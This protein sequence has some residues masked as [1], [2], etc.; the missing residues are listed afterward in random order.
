MYLDLAKYSM[1]EK[2]MAKIAYENKAGIERLSNAYADL[3]NMDSQRVYK[4]LNWQKPIDEI[5]SMQDNKALDVLGNSK[6]SYGA[7]V[8]RKISEVAP[9]QL[10]DMQNSVDRENKLYSSMAETNSRIN[11]YLNIIN[12]R[13]DIQPP[14]AESSKMFSNSKLENH[15]IDNLSDINEEIKRAGRAKKVRP[16]EEI[17][18][19]AKN[20]AKEFKEF[21]K[22]DKLKTLA[23][24]AAAIG[25]TTAFLGHQYTANANLLSPESKPNGSGSPAPD[26]SYDGNG[27]SVNH[28]HVA[29][30][31]GA[32]VNTNHGAKYDISGKG[33]VSD[34][35]SLYNAIQKIIRKGNNDVNV[36]VNEN[37]NTNEISNNWLMDKVSKLIGK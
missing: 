20:T 7:Y 29:P 8:N 37:D 35:H 5:I 22:N 15:V 10:L 28:L 2:P 1:I 23:I 13:Q 12:G 24:A 21:V 6:I 17:I 36:T 14:D 4:E 32:I 9:E 11:A 16:T 3:V 30:P 18:E 34:K 25:I 31:T 33:N 26:G 19:N 27:V